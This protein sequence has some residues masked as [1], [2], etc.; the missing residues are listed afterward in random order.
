VTTSIAPIVTSPIGDDS[1]A[2]ESDE[3]TFPCSAA[4]RRAWFVYSLQPGNPALNIA[5]RWELRGAVKPST[6][7]QAFQLCTDRHEILRTKFAEHDGE[8]VQTVANRLKVKLAVVDLTAEE[9]RTCLEKAAE[10]GQEEARRPFDIGQL[11]LLRLTLL[12]LALDRAYLLVTAHQMIFDGWAIRLLA[13]ELGTIAEGLAA[14]RPFHVPELPLQYGDYCLWQKE[15]LASKVLDEEITYWKAKLA[16]A[17]YFEVLPDHERPPRLSHRGELMAVVLPP[18]IGDGLEQASRRNNMTL[19][20]FACGVTAAMLHRCTGRSDVIFG[21]QIAGRDDPDLENLIGV[22]INNLVLRFDLGGDPKFKELLAQANETVQDALIHQRMPFDKLVEILNPPRDPART[23]LISVNFTVLNDDREPKKYGDFYLSRQP[24]HPT[25]SLYDLNF[26]LLRWP[27]G[28]RLALEYKPELFEKST[29][30]RLLDFF[31]T[32][33]ALAVSNPDARL[34]SLV[35]PLRDEI[36][37]SDFHDGLNSAQT[38]PF[39]PAEMGT[40]A[41]APPPKLVLPLE[42]YGRSKKVDDNASSLAQFAPAMVTE[43][44]LSGIEKTLAEIWRDV[45]SVAEIGPQS[46]F[47]TLGGHSLSA[48]RLF[49]RVGKTLGIKTDVSM[50]FEAPTLREFAARITNVDAPRKP[51]NIVQIQPKGSKTP[52]IAINNTATYYNLA[53]AIGVDRPF[54]G[55]QLFDPDGPRQLAPRS[56]KDIAADYVELVRTVRPHGPY[57][58]LGHCLAGIIAYETAHQLQEAGEP[59]RLVIM[60]DAWLPGYA[61]RIVSFRQFFFRLS[62]QIHNKLHYGIGQG[63]TEFLKGRKS[64]P[65]YLV[66]VRIIRNSGILK[67]AA[68]LRLIKEPVMPD[69]EDWGNRWFLPH[70]EEAKRGY[71][72]PET[73][74]D[75]VLLQ[76][77][78]TITRFAKKDMAW[79]NVVKGRLFIHRIPGWLNDMFQGVGGR[80]IAD[81]LRPLLEEADS[82][83]LER[84]FLAETS[85]AKSLHARAEHAP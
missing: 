82:A 55:V 20:S 42:T 8:L 61:R 5:L 32:A 12:R 37:F 75:V 28:W 29:V 10:L 59:V 78:G 81:H 36:V 21:T 25:G 60:S 70:L 63:F 15:Y 52:I 33:V 4:Q 35:P 71:S 67:L 14:G 58:L 19:F 85:S 74:C 1:A 51:W 13:H 24:S 22:F 34:S 30:K 46:N 18:E 53:R 50:L 23:P 56:M 49:A 40:A 27:E 44:S 47:F 69:E 43:E 62:Y 79:S 83:Y 9:E 80:L 57:I 48:L 26:S 73:K 64:L 11:P 45:L 17:A 72:A 76:S 41:N 84:Q 7:E 39:S 68:R 38:P 65:Q 3:L 66:T 2:G 54:I 77:D 6:I 16:G 31:N